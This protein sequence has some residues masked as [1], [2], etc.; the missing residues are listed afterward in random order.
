MP[1]ATVVRGTTVTG[2][3]ASIDSGNDGQL[4]TWTP[5]TSTSG[6]WERIAIAMPQASPPPPSGTITR[7]SSGT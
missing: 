1:S 3:P 7:L 6:R 5:I 4:S 2:S